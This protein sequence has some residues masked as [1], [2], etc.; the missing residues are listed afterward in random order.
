MTDCECINS[1]PFINDRMANE[2]GTAE[3]LKREYC[4]GD[5]TTCARFM[6]FKALGKPKVPVDMFPSQVDRAKKVI[7]AG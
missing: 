2:P 7:A 1:C 3:G 6:V 5:Y 4:Q